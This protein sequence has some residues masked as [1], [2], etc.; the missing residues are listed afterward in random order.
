LRVGKVTWDAASCSNFLQINWTNVGENIGTFQTLEFRVSRQIDAIRNLTPSTSFQI[1]LIA[2]GDVPTGAAV[3][4]LKYYN[5]DGPV[6]VDDGTSAGFLHPILATVRIPL[7]DFAGANL[8]NVRGV[9]FIFSDTMTGAINLANVR[10]VNL[11]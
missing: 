10:L 4:L 2:A 5:L 7:G 3:S 1:Q 9:R 6:G 11:P 8:S